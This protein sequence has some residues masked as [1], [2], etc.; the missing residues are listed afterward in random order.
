MLI[1]IE[2]KAEKL[3]A[4]RDFES[5]I[6]RYLP[7]MGVRNIGFPGGNMDLEIFSRGEGELWSGSYDADDASI[8]RYWNGFGIFSKDR[9]TQLI[10]VEINVPTV[11]NG[12]QVSGLFGKDSESGVVYLLHDGGVGGGRKGIGKGAF[13]SWSRLMPVEVQRADGTI[14]QAIPI[15]AINAPDLV[16]RLTKFVKTVANFKEAAVGEFALSPSLVDSVA[17]WDRYL[18]EASGERRGIR[19]S[20]INFVTRHGDVVE[21]LRIEREGIGNPNENVAN[22]PLIDLYVRRDGVITEL[23][24]VKTSTDRQ[25]L[26]T[27]IGQLMTHC[28]NG[29]SQ[30]S[31]T[32]VI[33]EGDI[34]AD[35]A[36]CLERLNI[37][38]RRFRIN[39]TK[40]PEIVLR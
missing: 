25:C 38:L 2:D 18:A 34:P 5:Q 17:E 29:A 16:A 30:P 12:A 8:A 24:E 20:E 31:K 4:Q 32:L 9:R 26:Y 23:Y 22:S 28:G 39:S 27:A 37:R 21:A 35:L 14:R 40:K 11:S 3:R 10:T 19:N 33:P 15:A 1:Q 6:Q 7:S 13:F 36:D